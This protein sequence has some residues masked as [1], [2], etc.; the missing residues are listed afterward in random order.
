MDKQVPKQSAIAATAS[1]AQNRDV[2]GMRLAMIEVYENRSK[3]F[4]DVMTELHLKYNMPYATLNQT[5]NPVEFG[6]RWTNE[7]A[8]ECYNILENQLREL[9]ESIFSR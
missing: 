1:I 2:S 8:R 7:K 9:R 3:P 4:V 5:G 6:T